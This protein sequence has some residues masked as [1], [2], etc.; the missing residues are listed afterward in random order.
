M[1]GKYFDVVPWAIENSMPQKTALQKPALGVSES[2][3]KFYDNESVEHDSSKL[4]GYWEDQMMAYD[5]AHSS[6]DETESALAF[7]LTSKSDF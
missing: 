3:S 7:D 1:L 6:L 4:D 5:S 2:E